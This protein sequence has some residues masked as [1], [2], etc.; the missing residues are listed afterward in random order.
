MKYSE[1]LKSNRILIC[2]VCKFKLISGS[3]GHLNEWGKQ[4][5]Q[6]WCRNAPCQNFTPHFQF[7]P[8]SGK[9]MVLALIDWNRMFELRVNP[10]ETTIE[11]IEWADETNQ[12]WYRHQ[13]TPLVRVK[14]TILFDW[15]DIEQIKK[16]INLL[17]TFS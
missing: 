3:K 14:E 12:T 7:E 2:P 17:L 9:P 5:F 6:A 10:R 8:G 4:V 1:I 11:P 16:K 13:S 15:N